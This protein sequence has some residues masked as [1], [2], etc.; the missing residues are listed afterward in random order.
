M[1]S[2]KAPGNL[3]FETPQECDAAMQAKWPVRRILKLLRLGGIAY[4][5]ASPIE[6]L[7]FSFPS[8]SS[9]PFMTTID[10]LCVKES[11]RRRI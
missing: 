7:Q 11:V 8:S 9:S 5:F 6:G 2:K 3:S 4:F 1:A 10:D